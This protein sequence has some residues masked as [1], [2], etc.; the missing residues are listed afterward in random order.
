MG[1]DRAWET[2]SASAAQGR[3]RDI[4]PVNT[5]TLSSE[6]MVPSVTRTGVT[7]NSPTLSMMAFFPVGSDLLAEFARRLPRVV[8]NATSD[9]NFAIRVALPAR[10]RASE[11]RNSGSCQVLHRLVRNA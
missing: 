4:G 2:S 8:S 10:G 6:S 3:L 5:V 11:L 9:A 1:A 7:L